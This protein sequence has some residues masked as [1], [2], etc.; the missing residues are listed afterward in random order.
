MEREDWAA[1][2]IA[3]GVIILG[4]AFILLCGGSL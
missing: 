3:A 2:L 4:V 1:W